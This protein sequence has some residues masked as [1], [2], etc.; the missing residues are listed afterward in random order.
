MWQL[1]NV[2]RDNS[3]ILKAP[4][5]FVKQCFRGGGNIDLGENSLIHFEYKQD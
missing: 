5:Y 4:C 3:N 2:H 1:L